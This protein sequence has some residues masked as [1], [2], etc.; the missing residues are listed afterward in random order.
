[1]TTPVVQE[2]FDQYARSR[3]EMDVDRIASQYADSFMMAGPSGARTAEKSA[4]L[5]A[6]ASGQ[7][8]LKAS[9]N[10]STGVVSLEET[11]LDQQYVLVRA[12]FVWRFAKEPAQ[13][14]DVTINSTL[15]LYSGSGAPMIVF[16]HER[17]DFQQALRASGVLPPKP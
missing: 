9:G 6:F 8:F 7:T 16:Q 17:E 14:K 5:A 1:M 15:V 3:T 2:F 13:P 12:Q 10:E 11:R 4:I